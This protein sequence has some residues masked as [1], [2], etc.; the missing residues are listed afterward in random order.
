[1]V[2]RVAFRRGRGVGVMAETYVTHPYRA[3]LSE[4]RIHPK[5]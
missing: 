1:M 3:G 4:L 5:P 2:T